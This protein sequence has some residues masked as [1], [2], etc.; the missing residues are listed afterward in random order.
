MQT[1]LWFGFFSVW[2]LKSSWEKPLSIHPLSEK[3]WL[4]KLFFLA[5]IQGPFSSNFISL[6]NLSSPPCICIYSLIIFL[7]SPISECRRDDA[8]GALDVHQRPELGGGP[9]Q[10]E[11]HHGEVSSIETKEK[12]EDLGIGL[13]LSFPPWWKSVLKRPFTPSHVPGQGHRSRNLA[14]CAKPIQ[15]GFFVPWHRKLLSFDDPPPTFP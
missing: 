10:R 11:Q 4:R 7:F 6:G 5:S 2:L 1:G 3:K 9:H 15:S 12:N 14:Y 8:G 13:L